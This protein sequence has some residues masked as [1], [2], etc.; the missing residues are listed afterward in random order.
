MGGSGS[1]SWYRW[2]GSKDTTDGLN[3]LDVNWLNRG[4]YLTPGTSSSV[5]WTRNGESAGDV[6]LRAE[7]G[8][9]VLIYRS[10]SS[11]RDWESVEEPVP[12]VW[13]TCH[14]G[15]R[16]PWFVCPGARNGVRCGRKV[17]KLFAGG[18]YF[19]CRHCYD[20]VYDCQR[21]T[22]SHRLL[23]KAQDIRRRLGGSASMMDPFPWKPK[24]MH[25]KTYERLRSK[26][27][28]ADER[29]WGALSE[30]LDKTKSRL[31]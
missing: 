17:S 21:E 8:R 18:K 16:R 23:R 26:A 9:V 2:G 25:W 11:G 6:S 19:L 28:D 27:E 3:S 5:R 12:L 31:N 7:A 13:T 24:G 10:R 22:E 14:Y 15:G 1:G 4:G 30:W 20:L 29:S